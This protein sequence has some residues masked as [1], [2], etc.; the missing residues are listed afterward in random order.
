MRLLSL[1]KL[2]PSISQVAGE[3]QTKGWYLSKTIWSNLLV[4]AG[5]IWFVLTDSNALTLSHDEV[6]ALSVAAVAVGNIVL[7]IL[8]NKP[9]GL[10][11]V[12]RAPGRGHDAAGA[13]RHDL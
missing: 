8:T 12:P 3:L 9:V 11:S 2:L 4:M 10:R 6:A 13:H 1:L 7:R 5:S